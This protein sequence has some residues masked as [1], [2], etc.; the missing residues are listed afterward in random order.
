MGYTHKVVVVGAG[1]SGLVC[2]VR[3]KQRGVHAL[4][5][6]SENR[7]GGLIAT[8]RRNGILFEGGP[9]CPRFPESVWCLVRE[10][11]L[12]RE[13]VA[14]DK[15][16][17]RYIL[18]HGILHPSPFS[19]TGLLT[20]R[21]VGFGSKFRILTEALRHSHPPAHEESL[22]EFIKRKFDS[23]VLDNLIEPFIS[24]IFLGD[25]DRM[26]MESAFPA[27]VDWERRKGS[28][29]RGAVLASASNRRIG[30]S[31][32]SLATGAATNGATLHVTEAL[33]SLGSFKSGMERLPE[34]LAEELKGQIR[35][36]AKVE[37]VAPMRSENGM[38]SS[39]WRLH[40]SDGDQITTEFL[41]LAVPAHAAARFLA[42]NARQLGLLLNAI[43]YEPMCVVSAAYDRSSVSHGL[44]GFGFMVP[45]REALTTICTFWNSSL[46]EDRAPKG[47]VLMTSFAGRDRDN[48]V[49]TT[50]ENNC[51][52]TIE[53]ENAKILG[54]A[55]KPVDRA[56]W[57]YP[58]ALPQYNVGHARRVAMIQEVIRTFPN[59]YLAG[60]FLKGR[61]IGDCVDIASSVAKD[62]HSNL[63]SQNLQSLADYLVEPGD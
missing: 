55:S 24:T 56:V 21:L 59:L 63:H 44:D 4:M 32:A 60:N 18:R 42:D 34:K 51:V 28:V 41:V 54:L 58:K 61:S 3:L 35:Y 22:A 37:S 47:T 36:N 8:I 53:S 25:P 6:E 40:L 30:K 45:R 38:T 50:P 16:A 52:A 48:S 20:T 17:K 19:P 31:G 2:A 62:L 12:E 5:L 26:G 33:P 7:A 49:E 10:L 15:R 46:L 23:D 27:L 29:V 14:G 39:G 9:Q 57:R 1:I 13:F 11:G 43:E